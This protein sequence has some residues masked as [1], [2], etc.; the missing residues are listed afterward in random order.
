[1]TGLGVY[2]ASLLLSTLVCVLVVAT[3]ATRSG[4]GSVTLGLLMGG[5][6]LWSVA[7]LGVQLAADPQVVRLFE[8][9][10]YLGIVTVVLFFLLFALEFVGRSDLVTRR[11]VAALA[12]VPGLVMLLVFSNPTLHLFWRA[13]GSV[14]AA[15]WAH[16]AYSYLL[17][18]VATLL[19]VRAALRTERL[20]QGQFAA[21]IVAVFGP[22]MANVLY[23]FGPVTTDL[24]PVAFSISGVALAVAIREFGF[25]DVAPVARDVLVDAIEDA[26][27]VVDEHDRVTDTNARF[28]ALFG[29][30][31]VVGRPLAGVCDAD[32]PLVDAIADGADGTVVDLETADGTRCFEVTVSPVHDRRD[33]RLGRLVLL[34]DVT[35]RLERE[36]T[37]EEREQTYRTLAEHFPRGLVALFDADLRYTLVDGGL[38]DDIDWETTDFEG[39]RIEEVHTEAHCDRFLDSYE[40]VFD[41]EVHTF[42]FSFA[43]RQFR[44]QLVPVTDAEGNV[45][46]GMSVV[47]D[48]TELKERERALERQNER[49]EQVASVISHDLRNPLN[50][51]SGRTS[52]ARETGDVDHLA[53]VEDAHDRM[54][55]IIEDVLSLARHGHTV[56]EAE[57]VALAEVARDAWAHVDTADATLTVD[58]AVTVD[59]DPGRLSQVLENLYRNA[60]Q[61]GGPGVTV[62]VRATD[63]GFV[64]AD[65]GPGIPEADRDEV[66]EAGHTDHEDGTGLGLAI[67]RSIVEAHGWDVAVEE[68]ADGGASFRFSGL[69]PRPAAVPDR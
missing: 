25:M 14:T 8:Q 64:V 67:A 22:W 40:A 65:D 3:T 10:V 30:D 16:T 17:L 21:L 6:G 60:I 37:L 54:E 36:R 34:H 45:L 9:L 39:A 12:V 19:L 7:E 57:S 28:R 38:F 48:I 15:F 24:T 56:R 53:A 5:A 32:S 27:V 20:Y 23:L 55:D 2:E 68:S 69:D 33:R 50:V 26:M 31:D 43:G 59:A 52:L 63:D 35:E 1:M 29:V 4:P 46:L 49:L 62:T 44:T 11:L 51:A 13:D 41:G 61:H 42:T 47:T 18:S 66:F 58:A